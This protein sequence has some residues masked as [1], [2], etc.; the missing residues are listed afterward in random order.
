MA[1]RRA[2]LTQR[3]LAELIGC[4]QA[5]IARWERG[6]RQ[7]SYEDVQAVA[8]ACGLQV[9][10]HLVPADRSWW[11]QVAVQLELGPLQRVRALT[12]PGVFDVIPVLGCLA[13]KQVPA[14][15]IG[16]VAGA[17]QGWPLVLAG[18]TV[19]V[20]A[21]EDAS[22]AMPSTVEGEV[23]DG[24]RELPM[25]GGYASRK[26]HRARPDSMIWCAMPTPSRSRAR[27]YV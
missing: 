1:R 15:V 27:P 9:D 19:E 5:T 2:C 18:N 21:E 12:R 13:H 14:I 22:S 10:A 16:E 4:R 11:P 8:K 24:A 7:P 25:G 23:V 26:S 6:D 17:L 3:G 20:C